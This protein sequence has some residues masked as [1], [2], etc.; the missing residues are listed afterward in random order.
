MAFEDV[1][2]EI[3][4]DVEGKEWE[5]CPLYKIRQ[6]KKKSNF[7]GIFLKYPGTSTTS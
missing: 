6:K 7:C 3:M 4:K 2:L 5:D 1:V